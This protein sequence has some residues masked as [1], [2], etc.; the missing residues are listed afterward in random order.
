MAGALLG[1][2][3]LVAGGGGS[4]PPA[5]APGPGVQPDAFYDPAS[6]FRGLEAMR[7]RGLPPARDGALAGGLVPH[8]NLAG[9]MFSRFFVQLEPHP[10]KTVIV[11]G[12]NHDNRGQEVI[13]GRRGWSTAFGVVEADQ[14]LVSRL[15]E[16]GLAAIDDRS[17]E[18]EHA[19]GALMP[20]LKYHAPAAKVVPIILH[21]GVTLPQME[22]LAAFLAPQLSA[23][24]ILVASVDF[25]H[26][27]TRARAEAND[28]ITYKAIQ[29]F[30]LP[31]L[32][33]M[34]PDFVDSPPSL[35]VLMLAMRRAG[36]EGPA[37]EAHSNSGIL[38]GSDVAETTSY[39][40]LS[41]H[42]GK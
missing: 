9:E 34:G 14:D 27:L 4:V 22:R 26:Y 40:T 8:H 18:P 29:D 32:M 21:R 3:A 41:Y 20:Y 16:A 2:G 13:T 33:K 28:E 19:V 7:T 15:A 12:P 38:F 35:G 6:F 10:P 5:Q 17:L 30:D 23:D 11:V 36:A 24:T 37:L 31:A 39:F 1:G 25:S 42:V